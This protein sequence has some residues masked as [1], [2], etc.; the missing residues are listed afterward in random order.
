MV[1]IWKKCDSYK[2]WSDWHIFNPRMHSSITLLLT[3]V[4]LYLGMWRCRHPKL[5]FLQVVD[6][7]SIILLMGPMTS[8]QRLQVPKVSLLYGSWHREG[9]AIA[10]NEGGWRW[11]LISKF[12]L[13]I[14]HIRPY[15]VENTGSHPLSQSQAAEGLISSWVG[16]DQRIPAVVCVFFC[17]FV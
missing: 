9:Y 16:D 2:S 14:Y 10:P 17:C 1:P 7:P 4:L 3:D 15:P 11:A 8:F 5:H 6:E 12:T 13:Y